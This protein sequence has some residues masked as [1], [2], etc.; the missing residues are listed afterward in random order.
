MFLILQTYFKFW[1][2]IFG[3][4]FEFLGKIS[5]KIKI[6]FQNSDK[7]LGNFGS[8]DQILSRSWYFLSIWILFWY[9]LC[10][11]IIF[12]V[13]GTSSLYGVLNTWTNPDPLRTQLF[14]MYLNYRSEL[15]GE[16]NRIEPKPKIIKYLIRSKCLGPRDSDKEKWFVPEPKTDPFTG[17][18]IFNKIF[19]FECVSI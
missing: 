18:S 2:R 7:I 8:L 3:Y 16:R 15:S 1:D 4:S 17:S 12:G 14:Y 5:K 9:F 19:I 11:K 6:Y 10:F 13:S